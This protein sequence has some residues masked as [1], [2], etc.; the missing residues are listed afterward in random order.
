MSKKKT[1]VFK[2]D[3]SPMRKQT[4]PPTQ[5]HKKE[6]GAG[7]YDRKKEKAKKE[8]FDESKVISD[9]IDAIMEKNY[10]DAYKYLNSVVES[11]LEARIANEY[12]LPLF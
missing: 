10:A 9:F 1:G 8:T 6:K 5:V 11:K 7:S 12:H 3:G 4:S 2:K